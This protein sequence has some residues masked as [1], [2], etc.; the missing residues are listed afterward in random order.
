MVVTTLSS[1][2]LEAAC[3]GYKKV[4]KVLTSIDAGTIP[5]GDVFAANVT[6][7]EDGVKCYRA[8]DKHELDI[9]YGNSDNKVYVVS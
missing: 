8:A 4:A 1:A 9:H 5:W 7:Y 2:E 3:K 6:T